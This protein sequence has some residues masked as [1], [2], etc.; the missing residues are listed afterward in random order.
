MTN[1]ETLEKL[2]K[3]AEI[4]ILSADYEK[5][6][7]TVE[8]IADLD[9]QNPQLW[10]FK[11]LIDIKAP[12]LEEVAKR[13]QDYSKNSYY[14][15]SLRFLSEP[16]L[17]QAKQAVETS[18]TAISTKQNFENIQSIKDFI[19]RLQQK[20]KYAVSDQ[21]IINQLNP[22]SADE[23]GIVSFNDLQY[24]RYQE[25]ANTLYYELN[26]ITNLVK[27]SLKFQPRRIIEFGNYPQTVSGYD[28][29]PIKWVVVSFNHETMKALLVSLK[30]L[31]C[32]PYNTHRIKDLSWSTSSIRGWLN[33]NFYK[34]AFTQEQ[35]DKI[36][37]YRT[38][39][40]GVEGKND[41]LQTLDKVFLLNISEAM[42]LG[43]NPNLVAA[44][45]EYAAASRGENSLYMYGF[46]NQA[47]RWWL[48]NRGKGGKNCVVFVKERGDI[49]TQGHDADEK[50]FGVRPAIWLNVE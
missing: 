24:F 8:I 43:A 25:Q 12:S 22:L 21:T 45:T 18:K 27:T 19:N 26:H 3:K 38:F 46:G 1:Q 48:R 20:N 17:S 49:Y 37:V 35:K 42:L 15:M 10:L 4:E 44:P 32:L 31:D 9:I 39:G 36:A 14:Q 5:A 50:H 7:T 23:Y 34:V 28:Q 47:P 16:L 13:E 2:L 11:F 30:V 41:V 40:N 6:A 33:D 29:T